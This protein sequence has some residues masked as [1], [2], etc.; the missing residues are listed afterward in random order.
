MTCDVAASPT[1]RAVARRG[2]PIHVAQKLA[3]HADIETTQKYYLAAQDSDFEHAKRTQ[4]SIVGHLAQLEVTDPKLT[5]TG[6]KREF[7]KR[8]ASWQSP[9]PP[10]ERAV[11]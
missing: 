4:E 2:V 9:Q 3:G 8:K 1:G 5:Q 11:A 6:R 7:L 10:T